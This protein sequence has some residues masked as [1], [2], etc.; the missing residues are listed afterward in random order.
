MFQ[1]YLNNK[2]YLKYQSTMFNRERIIRLINNYYNKWIVLDL[3]QLDR[4]VQMKG[5]NNTV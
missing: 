1:K 5:W 2:I 4:I 3:I